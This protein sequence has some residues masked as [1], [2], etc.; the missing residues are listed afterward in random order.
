[1]YDISSYK[2]ELSNRISP[3]VNQLFQTNS[4]YQVKL[5]K[6]DMV[7]KLVNLFGKF[8]PQEMRNIKEKQLIERI[9]SILIIEAVSGTL[10]D[11]TPEQ[12]EI[13]DAVVEGRKRGRNGNCSW[14][15]SCFS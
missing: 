7:E 2:P 5:D 10:S 6:D 14:F 11:L 9:D 4:L 15:N 3:I 8:S 1:M 13:F 12:I